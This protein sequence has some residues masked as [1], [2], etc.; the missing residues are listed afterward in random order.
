MAIPKFSD[1]MKPVLVLGKEEQTLSNAVKKLSEQFNLTN[2]EQKKILPSGRQ[3]IVANRVSWAVTYLCKAG[4]LK[5]P[6]RGYFVI[7]EEGKQALEQNPKNIDRNFLSQFPG[8]LKFRD[9]TKNEIDSPSTDTS[10]TDGSSN[11]LESAL[12]PQEVLGNAYLEIKSELK[13]ELLNRV[14]NQSPDFFEE[15]VVKLLKG[16][17]YGDEE[18]LAKAIGGTNDG[19]V[20]GLVHQD[21]LGLDVV[22]IQAKRYAADNSVGRPALQA[23]IGTLS[24]KSATKGLFVTTSSFSS[25]AIDYLRTV[26]QRVVTVDGERLVELMVQHGVGVRTEQTYT[27]HR[28]DEDFFSE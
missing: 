24:G 12:T 20:D 19:G 27:I 23:F 17:G 13:S 26:P 28:I 4:L 21:K 7:T 14:L 9:R 15:L 3:T 5:R 8:Y 22:Y 10:S 11:S 2:E 6:R 18:N 25:Q 1:F 16:M